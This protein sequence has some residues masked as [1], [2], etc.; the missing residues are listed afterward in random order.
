MVRGLPKPEA[1]QGSSYF[2]APQ[3]L[4]VSLLPFRSHLYQ[5]HL[6]PWTR[7]L[8]FSMGCSMKQKAV[9]SLFL[10]LFA[11]KLRTSQ[12]KDPNT[13]GQVFTLLKGILKTL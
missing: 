2:I 6:I 5:G 4:C 8:I 9:T 13:Q 1:V 11:N 3:S 7:C 12:Q 10:Q